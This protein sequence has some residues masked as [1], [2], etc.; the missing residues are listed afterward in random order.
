MRVKYLKF[1][2]DRRYGV[3]IEMNRQLEPVK[4]AS[5]VNDAIGS[6]M[7]TTSGWGYSCNNDLWIV[8]PDS[9][10]GDLGDKHQ[11]GGG[12]EVASAVG[13]GRSHLAA[14]T[15]VTESLKKGKAKVNNHCGFH[16]QVEID[17]FD[18]A[19]AAILLAYWCKIESFMTHILPPHRLKTSHCR[20]FTT[21]DSWS[22]NRRLTNPTDF[23]HAMKLKKMGASAKRTTLTLVNF[24]R[25]RSTGSE[26]SWFKRPT[27]ELRYPE[28]SLESYDVKNWTRFFVHFVETCAN[29]PFPDDLKQGGLRDV[30]IILGLKTEDNFSVLSPGLFET[31]CWLLHRLKTYCRSSKLRSEMFAEAGSIFSENLK[32]K[33]D[34]PQ[35]LPPKKPKLGNSRKSC[36]KSASKSKRP[37]PHMEE[38]KYVSSFANDDTW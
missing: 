14:I 34:F 22:T 20:R 17:D 30:L 12:Y 31:K 16:C 28:S 26:W 2:S 21:K 29:R 1:E 10:C 7:A 35:V 32:W 38:Y 9:S 15:A 19:R 23:W 3:E 18:N 6:H 27:V 8:K 24:Q 11:D 4:V 25:S 33:F 5:L 37:T 13:R 36:K